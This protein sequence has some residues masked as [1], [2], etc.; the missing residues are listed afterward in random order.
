MYSWIPVVSLYY[1]QTKIIEQLNPNIFCTYVKFH[2]TW[3]KY[4]AKKYISICASSD[5][6]KKLSKVRHWQ[7]TFD[8]IAYPLCIYYTFIIKKFNI[9]YSRTAITI[10][11]NNSFLLINW[12]VYNWFCCIY[13]LSNCSELNN[14]TFTWTSIKKSSYLQFIRTYESRMN[15]F[16]LDIIYL[17]NFTFSSKLDRI[18]NRSYCWMVIFGT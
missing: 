1:F 4:V 18:I 12:Y 6:E 14:V 7:K 5:S 13:Y 16:L 9:K 2:F 15:N 3:K 10:Y 8:K 11:T 17:C